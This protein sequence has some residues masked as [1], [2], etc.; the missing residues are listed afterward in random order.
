MDPSDN[1]YHFVLIIIVISLII[2]A[3]ISVFFTAGPGPVQNSNTSLIPY[4]SDSSG[5][6]LPSPGP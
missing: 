6:M 5:Q 1:H 4:I 3:G 2:A